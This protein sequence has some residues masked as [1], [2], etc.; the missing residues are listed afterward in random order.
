[1]RKKI[2]IFIRHPLISGS[3]ILFIGSIFANIFNFLF[4]LFMTRNLS[5]SDY[6]ILA[7]L[8]S[9]ITLFSLPIGSMTPTFV[10]FF[11]SY[12]AQEDFGMVRGLYFKITKSFFWIAT[13]ILVIFF[14][15]I[16][17]IGIFFSIHEYTLLIIV[18]FSIWIS[19]V[20]VNNSALLQAK[21][22]FT[23]MTITN[24][25]WSITKLVLGVIF[26]FLGYAVGG[27]M[28]ALFLCTVVSYITSFVPLR[29]LFGKKVHTPLISIKKLFTYGIPATISIFGMTA[30]TTTDIILVKHYFDPKNAGIYA[31]IS[32]IARAIFFFS[33]PIATVMF[34]LVVKRYTRKEHYHR[35]FWLAMLL[36]FIPSVTISIFYFMFPEFT[37]EFFSKKQ[38]SLVGSGYL[39]LLAIYMTVYA[40][41]F[42]LTNFFLSIKKTKVF[43]PIILSAILQGI[44]ILIFHQNFLQ[45][46]YVSILAVSL[47][48]ISL[49]LYYWKI[50]HDTS[51]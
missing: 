35:L 9:F 41:I 51:R 31:T 32:L 1:M 28:F 46:I 5:V 8:N 20:S 23:F 13:I 22:E 36:V 11:A 33:S 4:N 26:V 18:G 19:I 7:S 17:Y 14:I 42:L 6:G 3:F 48:L 2:N 39:G 47:L 30:L 27:V 49:L 43:I 45:V 24:L 25:I 37:I 12:L 29:F 10:H 50:Y 44:G 21:Q 16:K 38:E 40:L 34:P 15:F